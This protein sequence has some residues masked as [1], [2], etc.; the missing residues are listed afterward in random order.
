MSSAH[1]P[2]ASASIIHSPKEGRAGSRPDWL[3][4]K[5]VPHHCL[6]VAPAPETPRKVG[7]SRDVPKDDMGM[8]PL[9]A[10]KGAKVCSVALG[11]FK[12][13]FSWA[14]PVAQWL[15]SLAP[16]RWPRVCQLG[17]WVQTYAFLIKPCCGRRPMYKIEGHG[18]RC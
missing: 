11:P 2:L 14:G 10:D 5:M 8:G 7:V 15:S 1:G 3:E 17:S 18:Y 4:P 12:N 6:G 13:I 9:R 16:L